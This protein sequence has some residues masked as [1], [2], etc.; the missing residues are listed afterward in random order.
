MADDDV[1][2]LSPTPLARQK[3]VTDPFEATSGAPAQPAPQ[4]QRMTKIQEMRQQSGDAYKD[5]SDIQLADKVHKKFYS[6]IPREDFYKR[7]GVKISAAD[8][9]IG[10]VKNLPGSALEFGKS[11]VQ[12]IMHPIETAKNMYALGHGV[13]QKLGIASGEDDVKM[14]DAFGRMLLERY[15][16][17]ENIKHTLATDPVGLAADASMFMTGGGSAAARVPGV[18]GRVGRTVAEAGRAI[19]PLTAPARAV[20][21]AYRGGKELL[22][23]TAPADVRIAAEAGARGGQSMQQYQRAAHGVMP[24]AEPVQDI[25]RV[26]QQL[27]RQRNT[28]Y[29]RLTAQYPQLAAPMAPARVNQILNNI[30]GFGGMKESL[31]R[32]AGVTTPVRQATEDI[33]RLLNAYR[34]A[35]PQ[36]AHTVEGLDALKQAISDIDTPAGSSARVLV[37]RAASAVR[38]ELIRTFPEYANHMRRYEQ[39]TSIIKEL[40]S[41]IAGKQG[42]NLNAQIKKLY[43]VLRETGGYRRTRELAEFVANAGAPHLMEKLAGMAAHGRGDWRIGALG[44]AIAE[45]AGWHAGIPGVG[46]ALGGAAGHV[47]S[48]PAV[49]D[50]A[51]HTAGRVSRVGRQVADHPVTRTGRN[52]LRVTV[53]PTRQSYEAQKNYGPQE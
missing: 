41:T 48:I 15:G 18:V 51:A 10:A 36:T 31:T 46:A 20:S 33:R 11:V 28:E 16:S 50:A 40:E 27:R 38:R 22:R 14:A 7:V 13:M 42:G 29:Q 45:V 43:R 19:D 25:Q 30:A 3:P 39:A 8:V 44:A 5:L 12:P 1:A 47:A 32:A 23:A 26:T 2:L 35:P 34:R 9:G 49:R 37:N 24:E 21:G 52:V 4:P 6:D 17:I 53:R